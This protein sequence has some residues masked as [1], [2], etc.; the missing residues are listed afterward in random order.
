MG[1][2]KIPTMAQVR[3]VHK[4]GIKVVSTFSG[5]G[6]SC[7]G[8]RMAGFE[9]VWASEFIAS[10]RETYQLNFPGAHVDPRDIREVSAEDILLRTG[11]E[12]G[13]LDVLEGS[14]PCASF[15]TAGQ[16]EK[17]WGQVKN[18]SETKQRTDDLFFEFVRILR[19]LKP[20]AFV[21]ENVPGLARGV[22]TVYLKEILSEL[23]ASGYR[24]EVALI[25][26]AG[27][28]VAQHR[29]RLIFMGYREDL[30]CGPE[31][32]PV[33]DRVITLRSALHGLRDPGLFSVLKP[34]AKLRRIYAMCRRGE[35]FDKARSRAGGRLVHNSFTHVRA[36]WDAPIATV[37][38][39]AST[40]Y[41]PDEPRTLG[42]NELRRCCSFPDDFQ[43]TGNFRQQ[44]ERF[45]RAVPPLFMRAIAGAV[46]STLEG[47]AL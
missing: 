1:T 21:A 29:E 26:A 42:I 17:H 16:R 8:F 34:G 38:A 23:R 33:S 37:T 6:G 27:H 7:L 20:R 2:Y 40:V 24:V 43:V 47:T 15:S 25:N 19:G 46:K 18:Y 41:H 9:V 31:Y 13:E 45:G 3:R 11:L 10:A 35:H 30:G 44:W 32:P 28:G 14:P 5:C 12:V 22:A 39:T 36:D 4:N